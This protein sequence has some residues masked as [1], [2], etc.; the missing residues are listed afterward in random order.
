M[1]ILVL[2]ACRL[3]LSPLSLSPSPSATQLSGGLARLGPIPQPWFAPEM[4]LS[5]AT[6]IV[7]AFVTPSALGLRAQPW[8][9]HGD[10]APAWDRV[11]TGDFSA[12]PRILRDPAAKAFGG[13]VTS[14]GS[15]A[16][17]KIRNIRMQVED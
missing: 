11:P 3:E 13:A 6:S 7:Q 14:K 2:F 8:Q 9:H 1:L 4:S 10:R 5:A 17:N 15:A 16:F 12:G